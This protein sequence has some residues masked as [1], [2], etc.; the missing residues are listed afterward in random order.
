MKNKICCVFNLAP[1]YRLSIYKLM[2]EQLECD[3]YFGDKVDAPI[4]L[5]NYSEL[6]GYKSE[7][8]NSKILNTSFTWQKGAWKLIFKPYR[9]YI[10]NGGP[11]FLAN[12]LILFFA[13]L[14]GKKVHSWDHG[15]K[16]DPATKYKF[17]EYYFYKLCDTV[18]LYGNYSKN[19]MLNKGFSKEKLVCI[20]NSLDYER[21]IE[22]R[23]NLL[24]TKIYEDYFKNDAPVISYI[25]RIQKSKKIDLLIKAIGSLNSANIPCNLIVIGP[26]VENENMSDKVTQLNLENNVWFYGPCYDEQLIGD[27]LYN[28][29][30]CVTP[31]AI[32][33][34]A[35]HAMAYGTPVITSD[36]FLIHG[37]EF[38]TITPDVTG[39]FFK[40]DNLEDLTLKIK[41]WINLNQEEQKITK[42]NAF[43]VIDDKYNP[44]YQ[45][46][47]LKTALK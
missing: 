10:I 36:N 31:G 39:D 7:L 45:I 8:K 14:L 12:W 35:I 41:K 25:G 13:K 26:N 11:N 20:Y 38:E 6:K 27:L 5:L 1:H 22:I 3:F 15:M 4:K 40:N 16:G 17:F 18:F 28:S 21:Q 33:L 42:Q 23:Q 32:G 43:K 44:L 19:V 46:E 2:D 30:V 37:P 29:D 24:K 9:H 34:T 47:V